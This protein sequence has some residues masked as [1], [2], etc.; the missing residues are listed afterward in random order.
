M[1]RVG[2]LTTIMAA[3]LGM[4]IATGAAHAVGSSSSSSK[5]NPNFVVG[6]KAV[7]AEKWQAAIAALKKVV[8]TD[9]SNAD[10]ENLLGYSYRK[11]GDY[12]S[13]IRH[14]R[15]ALQIN[16]KHKGAHEYIGEAYLELGNLAKAEEHLKALDKICT[17]GCSEYEDIKKAIKAYKKANSN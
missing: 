2:F 3:I 12:N 9:R 5:P 8:K 1:T 13:A 10:A 16:P 4:A 6:K 11:M 15:L 7:E 17:F 14:Y